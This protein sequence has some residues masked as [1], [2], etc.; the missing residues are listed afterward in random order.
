MPRYRLHDRTE[1]DP[2]LVEQ[3]GAGE[4]TSSPRRAAGNPPPRAVEVGGGLPACVP[5]SCGEGE[6]RKPRVPASTL[7]VHAR[8]AIG[9]NYR[10][11]GRARTAGQGRASLSASPRA[12][13]PPAGKGVSGAATGKTVPGTCREQLVGRVL[14]SGEVWLNHASTEVGVTFSCSTRVALS[15][16]MERA[17]RTREGL[18]REIRASENLVR[19]LLAHTAELRVQLDELEDGRGRERSG[20]DHEPERRGL[21]LRLVQGRRERR[22]PHAGVRP[23]A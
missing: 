19:E 18:V 11:A 1:G 4:W 14:L 9:G 23:P 20:E 3:P 10:R 16:V 17:E 21:R 7:D 6:Q 12:G 22:K 15:E 13:R 8:P 2:G 5:W